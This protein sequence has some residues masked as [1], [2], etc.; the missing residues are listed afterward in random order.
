MSCKGH[1]YVLQLIQKGRY[2]MKTATVS[3]RI[4]DQ[5][6]NEAE[7]VLHKLGLP[8]SVVIDSLYRQIIFTRGIPFPLSLPQP[9]KTMEEMTED[10]LN[11]KLQRGYEQALAGQGRPYKEVFE[12]LRRSLEA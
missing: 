3:A 4:D 6:K 8:V 10:E 7:D 11:E 1:D 2:N 5:I 12:E 9:P